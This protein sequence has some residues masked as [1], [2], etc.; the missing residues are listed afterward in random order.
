ML[1]QTMSIKGSGIERA[2]AA[3][4]RCLESGRR[5]LVIDGTEKTP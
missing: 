4:P 5:I 2:N 1:G 3:L